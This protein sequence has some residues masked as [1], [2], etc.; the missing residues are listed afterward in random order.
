MGSPSIVWLSPT[1]TT[2][3][4]GSGSFSFFF[5]GAL[6]FFGAGASIERFQCSRLI[7]VHLI[8][9]IHIIHPFHPHYIENTQQ[10]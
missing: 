4:F 1:G 3:V 10:K 2:L 9:I 6:G 5:R 8:N 7:F